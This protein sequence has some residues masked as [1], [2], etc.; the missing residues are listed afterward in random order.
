MTRIHRT[1]LIATAL[2]LGV[3]GLQ[4]AGAQQEPPNLPPT[5][6]SD[7]PPR[8]QEPAPLPRP[9]APAV[10]QSAPFPNAAGPDWSPPSPLRVHNDQG[11]RY[12]S[13]GVGESERAELNARSS[14]FN[15][16]LLFAMQGSGEYL[17]AIRVNI[18]DTHGGAILTADSKGPWFLAQLAPGDYAVEVNVPGQT[19][20]QPQRQTVHIGGSG[21]SRLDFYWR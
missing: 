2:I 6:D 15:L 19:G 7:A 17:S 1:S 3:G 10:S 16:R 11:V 18:L 14:Q 8:Y 13:G 9:N 4:A 21:Q 20:Q 12:I 5:Y